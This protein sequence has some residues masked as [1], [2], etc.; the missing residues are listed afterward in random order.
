MSEFGSV[1]PFHRLRHLDVQ[2][3]EFLSE[4]KGERAHQHEVGG[5]GVADVCGDELHVNKSTVNELK[6]KYANVTCAFCF[7]ME[8]EGG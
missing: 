4:V 1:P 2:H 5:S 8:S 7:L 3:L 6:G